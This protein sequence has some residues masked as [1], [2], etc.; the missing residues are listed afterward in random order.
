MDVYRKRFPAIFLTQQKRSLGMTHSTSD[1]A[2]TPAVKRVQERKG[3][4]K[5]YAKMEEKGGW[6]DTITEDLARFIDR[7]DSFYLG[8][9][10]ADGQPYIQHRRKSLIAPRSPKK[11]RGSRHRWLRT[12]GTPAI[13]SAW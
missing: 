13:P 12:P 2:F 7:R 5:G 11:P 9:A 6:R 1:I 10:S 3:S 4:R 8:T